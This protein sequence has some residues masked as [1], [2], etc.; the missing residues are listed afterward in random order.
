MKDML[1][2]LII[3][4]DTSVYHCWISDDNNADD[5]QAVQFFAKVHGFSRS[6]LV[7]SYRRMHRCF[8][9]ITRRMEEARESERRSR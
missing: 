2:S 5:S 8:R 4:V 7:E 6:I 1:V 3:S 9:S